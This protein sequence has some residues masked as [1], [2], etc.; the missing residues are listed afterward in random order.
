V[1]LGQLAA[2]AETPGGACQR[3]EAT[4]LPT[5]V[6]CSA[7]R[8]M[9]CLR[10]MGLE[11]RPLS[12][13]RQC[14]QCQRAGEP[15]ALVGLERLRRYVLEQKLAPR[16]MDVQRRGVRDLQKYGQALGV[17]VLPA[18]SAVLED[19]ITYSLLGREVPL[20]GPTVG[21]YV[22]GVGQWHEDA[23]HGLRVAL[24]N[25]AKASGVRAM[26]R[27]ARVRFKKRGTKAKS[28]WTLAEY[29]AMLERGFP[30]TRSGR[31][32]RIACIVST[33]GV[34]R[35]RGA[36]RL[37]VYH[38]FATSEQGRALVF[39]RRS[40]FQWVKV[41]SGVRALRIRV[42][43]DKNVLGGRVRHAYLPERVEALGLEPAREVME[44]IASEGVPSGSFLLAAPQGRRGFRSTE[45]TGACRA[46]QKAFE[47]AHP[48]R[49]GASFGAQSCRKSLASWLWWDGQSKRAIAD[50]GGWSLRSRKDA[51]DVYFKTSPV[52]LL[53]MLTH[54]GQ[55]HQRQLQE[56]QACHPSASP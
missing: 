15:E 21:Q 12:P 56:L 18:T 2:E 52:T 3:C 35:P 25:P 11:R 34:L 31:H 47:R 46:F 17:A 20:D 55:G 6:Y 37:R 23:S 27:V 1:L 45:Y 44:Y 48:G 26:L 29:K 38:R 19:Y 41:D 24:R 8:R 7:C 5:R 53:H 36:S 40:A 14:P 39:E 13:F 42:T 32:Q 51:V 16:T 10:C 49:S 33:F 43:K 9:T 50:Q 28:E 22:H 30:D 54:L 4:Q